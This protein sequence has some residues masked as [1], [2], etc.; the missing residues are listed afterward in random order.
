MLTVLKP[1][2]H[3]NRRF[4]AGMVVSEADVAGG[5]ISTA[6]LL[7]SGFLAPER[8]AAPSAATKRA[9]AT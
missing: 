3:P 5:S 4:A 2:P 9:K 7:A 8:P 6:E 1:F